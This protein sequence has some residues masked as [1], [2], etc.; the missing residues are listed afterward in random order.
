VLFI[1]VLSSIA[2]DRVSAHT[3]NSNNTTQDKITT[4]KETKKK[5][6]GYGYFALKHEL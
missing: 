1:Y 6:I 3:N 2:S 4:T 5:I